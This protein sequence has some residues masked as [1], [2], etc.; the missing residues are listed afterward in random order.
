MA[1]F[2][3]YFG[4]LTG[5]LLCCRPSWPGIDLCGRNHIHFAAL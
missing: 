3:G 4:F 2:G 1:R 5:Q